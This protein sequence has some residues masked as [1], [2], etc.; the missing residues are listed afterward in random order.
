MKKAGGGYTPM[1]SEH[2]VNF[3]TFGILFMLFSQ[4]SRFFFLLLVK[5][6]I[7]TQSPIPMCAS[8]VSVL[9][10]PFIFGIL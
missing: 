9:Y 6:L 3:P 5:S 1:L 8:N 7:L 10:L 4:S 2:I